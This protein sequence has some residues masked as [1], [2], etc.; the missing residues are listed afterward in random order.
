MCKCVSLWISMHFLYFFFD[1]FF[2]FSC[3]VLLWI[4]W[5]WFILYYYFHASLFS[6]GRQKDRDSDG[7]WEGARQ[8]GVTGKETVISIY[9]T[10]LKISF[11]ERG[12]KTKNLLWVEAWRLWLVLSHLYT[13][14]TNSCEILWKGHYKTPLKEDYFLSTRT[15]CP[16][17]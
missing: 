9:Y 3:F 14:R 4:V 15:Q 1:F 11:N 5:L 7:S 13:A 10:F 2:L 8:E 16:A 12:R 6:N 17:M